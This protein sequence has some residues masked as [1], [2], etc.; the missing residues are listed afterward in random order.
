MIV[1]RRGAPTAAGTRFKRGL[2]FTP[3]GGHAPQ[4]AEPEEAIQPGFDAVP[5][6]Q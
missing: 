1:A 3:A 4:A 2:S 6:P 5:V